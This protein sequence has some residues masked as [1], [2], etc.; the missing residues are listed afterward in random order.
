MARVEGWS[1]GKNG[2]HDLVLTTPAQV[3]F[4]FLASLLPLVL[5]GTQENGFV[6]QPSFIL[7]GELSVRGASHH[8]QSLL[9][10]Q[11]L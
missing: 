2:E 8:L 3:S 6:C 4:S 9:A 5:F 1:V 10:A 11:E 7:E